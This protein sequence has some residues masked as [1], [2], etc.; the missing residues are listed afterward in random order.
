LLESF[1]FLVTPFI[2]R[3]IPFNYE[4]AFAPIGQ[5]VSLPYVLVVKRGFPARNLAEFV[6][7]AKRQPGVSY[8][9]P[10][11]GSIGHLA[12]ALLARRAGISLEHV[13]YRGG[14][15]SARD[16]AAGVIDSA[17]GTANSFRPLI[18]DG[19]ATGLALT[20]GE[21]RGT[22][23][24]LPTIAE[25]SYPGYDLTSWN[26]IFAPA[27]TPAPVVARLEAALRFACADPTTRE[28]LTLSGNDVAAEG[29]AEFG[30]RL[31]R[32]R[33]LVRQIVQETGIRAE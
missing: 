6:A 33:A 12:G 13:P 3:N 18:E 31:Q 10:G 11:T 28:R 9:T 32:E 2:I 30:A 8:G 7:E 4:T 21:R 19:R 27:A 5:A 29:A 14:S 1:G 15:E 24:S 23:A 16:I 25:S 17:I 22:L 20:S 26:G